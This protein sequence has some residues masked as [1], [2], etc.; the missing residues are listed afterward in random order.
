[1][2]PANAFPVCEASM[3]EPYERRC[4]H[5]DKTYMPQFSGLYQLAI[6]LLA[7]CWPPARGSILC[8]SFIE[9]QDVL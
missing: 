9:N 2:V 5:L 8:H 3:F 7:V 1:M 4:C 6:S